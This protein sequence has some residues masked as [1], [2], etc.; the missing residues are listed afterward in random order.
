KEAGAL[1]ARLSALPE[2]AQAITLSSFVPEDQPGKLTLIEDASMLLG[3]T[4]NPT[5]VK[6]A[7]SD[8]ENAAAMTAM[9]KSLRE[10]AASSTTPAAPGAS[11]PA[12][13]WADEL[14]QLVQDSLDKR[15]AAT[16]AL[17]PGLKVMLGQIHS[18]LQAQPVGLDDLPADLKQDWLT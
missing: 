13:Q 10:A 8:Q 6:P 2:V 16:A 17:I 11:Q 14:D 3:T 18:T 4:L 5:D 1:A 7:P 12:R 9:A 15:D